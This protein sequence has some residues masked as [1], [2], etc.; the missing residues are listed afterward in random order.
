[1][2]KVIFLCISLLIFISLTAK[3][4]DDLLTVLFT[5][6][7]H[8]KAWA[9]DEPDNPGIGGL[10]ARL[11]IINEIRKEVKG[12]GGNI[13]ILSGGDITMGE[14]RSDVC[15]N[16][17]MI[18]GMNYI[19]YDGMVIGN[20]EFDFG[21]DTFEKMKE[22]AEFP[23][24]SANIYTKKGTK[25]IG[26]EYIQKKFSNGLKV[27]IIGLTTRETEQITASGL[28]GKLI[29]TDP[30]QEAKTRIPLL[31]KQNDLIIVAS[32]L[33]YYDTDKSFDGYYGDNYLA[34]TVPAIDLIVG[35]HTQR[36]L[37]APVKIGNTYIAQTG[38]MGKWVGRID[39]YLKDKKIIRTSYK[40]YPVNLK[41]KVVKDGKV[42]YEYIG[43]KI[44][45]NKTM[46]K[47]LDGFK[48][49]FPDTP[50]AKLDRDL[51]GNR[52][53]VRHKESELA[54]IIA[55]IMKNRVDA[56][57]SF[58]NAGSIREGLEKG[59]ITERDI[60]SMFPFSDTVFVGEIKGSDLRKILD[61]FAEKGS[62]AGGFL[63]VSGI[64][65]K[66]YQGAAL[67]VKINGK[68]LKENKKYKFA[69]NSFLAGGGDGYPL[70]RKLH[71]K[72]DTGYNVP[73]I[74]VEYLKEHKKFEKPEMGRIKIVK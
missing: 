16:L 73:A 60:Y 2:K 56:E 57:I 19:G 52:D 31:K 34:K 9:F 33:G 53:V 44:E 68:P 47:M 54:N 62:G 5:N 25:A 50:I 49:D 51:A 35:G 23:F 3:D 43:K 61:N 7:S 14:P 12:K 74:I 22:T 6:D 38:G 70:L 10:P 27:G 20:H 42:S 29:M 26:E 66:L 59:D 58:F 37:T 24:L 41:R 15:D 17:P 55:D 28:E 63:Q 13:L 36:N 72:K 48:C 30:I 4:A 71:S 8:G 69:T 39:F 45:Q 18:K 67:D 21:I 64:S 46:L 65:L 11:T 1:M 40:L 32:H